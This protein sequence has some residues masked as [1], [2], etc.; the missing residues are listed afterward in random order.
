MHLLTLLSYFIP[1][2][3]AELLSRDE[4]QRKGWPR[5]KGSRSN[6]SSQMANR[7][8]PS[9]AVMHLQISAELLLGTMSRSASRNG[10][11]RKMMKF[12]MSTIDAK[13][14]FG[15]H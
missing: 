8:L 6:K 13:M 15:T 5:M 3:R 10:I 14:S 9:R 7:I 12:V 1:P 4:L 2:D 11:R